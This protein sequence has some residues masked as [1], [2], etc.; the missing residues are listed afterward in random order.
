MSLLRVQGLSVR[1][2]GLQILDNVSLEVPPGAIVGLIGPNGAGK[3]TVFNVISG[4]VRPTTGTIEWDGRPMHPRPHGLA[5]LGIS[6]TLQG[7]GLFDSLTVA[8]NVL[9]GAHINRRGGTVSGLT[10][11]PWMLQRDAELHE[12]VELLLLKLGLDGMSERLAGE[13]PYPTRKRVSLARAL[14]SD[15][16]LI[17]LDEPAGG[18]SQSDIFVMSALLK[19]WTPE[20]S[21]LVVEHHMDFVM[22]TCDYIYV[23]DAGRIIAAGTPTEVQQNPAV[24]AAYL[25]QMEQ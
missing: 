19:S 22:S 20:R 5:Q 12:D 15:P 24:R 6:R 2:G 1:L 21:V 13:L 3:T 14:M 18:I 10:A 8:E 9:V 16:K 25:G 17:M 7:V 23:L 4:F 11:A